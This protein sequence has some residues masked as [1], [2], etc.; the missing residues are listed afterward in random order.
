MR[1]RQ[2]E[3]RSSDEAESSSPPE[4]PRSVAD[5]QS[6]PPGAT[7]PS[8]LHRTA[9]AHRSMLQGMRSGTLHSMDSLGTTPTARTEWR[10]DRMDS[11]IATAGSRLQLQP[12]AVGL[13]QH[14]QQ[15]QHLQQH[16]QQA[17][18]FG[19]G[20]AGLQQQEQ[21]RMQWNAE[22]EQV[23][24]EEQ[25]AQV[26]T[27][28]FR[29]SMHH[30]LGSAVPP[31]HSW[32]AAAAGLN[33]FCPVSLAPQPSS[34]G[35]AGPSGSAGR[36]S[37]PLHPTCVGDMPAPALM[38]QQQQQLL[39]CQQAQQAQQLHT[40]Y[41]SWAAPG[42]EQMAAAAGCLQD[43]PE[44]NWAGSGAA[45]APT[46]GRA[47]TG[48]GPDQSASCCN[49]SSTLSDGSPSEKSGSPAGPV[50]GLPAAAPGLAPQLG[51][52][53]AG[54]LPRVRGSGSG[55][56]S[57]MDC[58]SIMPQH[59]GMVHGAAAQQLAKEAGQGCWLPL[60]NDAIPAPVRASD[61]LPISLRALHLGAGSISGSLPE[62]T[63]L[64]SAGEACARGPGFCCLARPLCLA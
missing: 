10:G 8:Q 26:W 24:H 14:A 40:G 20:G 28:A 63:V 22:R 47:L 4:P 5:F 51:T 59:A 52:Q 56:S 53:H 42:V 44:A 39:L 23:Q 64:Q 19:A 57:L 15:A 25:A 2:R 46:Q 58:G 54:L 18:S 13:Y 33:P 35:A 41:A 50:A 49:T 43:A 7:T 3:R 29:G 6:L 16:Q 30:A 9:S 12:P 17:Q 32:L 21:Q 1:C 34:A 11:S 36:H 61:P 60:V 38:H 45:A 48:G 27:Q 55:G 31:H 37:W 62:P